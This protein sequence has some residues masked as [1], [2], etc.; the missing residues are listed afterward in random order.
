VSLDLEW[1][2]FS[3]PCCK[4]PSCQQHTFHRVS[5]GPQTQSSFLL[6]APRLAV[7]LVFW[8]L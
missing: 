1:E 5:N 2:C 6:S 4:H 8:V 7:I 3:F